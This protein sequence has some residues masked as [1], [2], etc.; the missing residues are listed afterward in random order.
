MI[1]RRE[2]KTE[3]RQVWLGQFV[4]RF[5]K[6]IGSDTISVKPRGRAWKIFPIEY[7]VDWSLPYIVGGGDT[8]FYISPYCR[9]REPWEK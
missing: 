4:N 3:K 2:L 7:L 6:R 5:R 1:K 9:K 8:E